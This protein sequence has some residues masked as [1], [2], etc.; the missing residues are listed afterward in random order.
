VTRTVEAPENGMA[1]VAIVI[2]TF[3]LLL[4]PQSWFP[5][6]G[7]MRIA[8]L[9]AGLAAAVL[10]WDRWTRREKLL[11]LTPEVILALALLGWAS[12]TLPLSYWPGGS[13]GLLTNMYIKSLAAFWLLAN[14]VTTTRRL[15]FLTTILG[16]CTAPLALSAFRH[17]AGGA[18]LD[19]GHP[20]VR[21]IMGYQAGLTSNPNDLALML[22]LILPLIIANFLT[23][24]RP[25]MRVFW[26]VLIAFDV[27]GVVLTFS[28]GGFLGLAT[29][30]VVYFVKLVRRPEDRAWAFAVLAVAI[31][32]LPLLPATYMN[33]LAT[34]TN[35]ESDVTGSA[36]ERWR[37]QMAALRFVM[38]HPVTGAG[39]GMDILA[40]N[41]MRGEQWK[42]VHNVYFQYAV[43]L[44]IPGV[45]LFLLLQWRVFRAVRTA[46]R[47]SAE[48]PALRDAHYLAGGLQV[49]LIVFAI[50]ALFHPVA[51]HFYFYY[52]AALALAARTAIT[53]LVS[54]A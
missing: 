21:R 25:G 50:A 43:D 48:Q 5:V 28:R 26:L 19:A 46:Q 17:F 41:Q 49:S 1:F 9:A 37:D 22:N 36:Q 44:G 7:K 13:L 45:T 3:I 29:I 10:L 32:S 31:L 53:A 30:G 18:Y 38:D 52:I 20:G 33:R 15:R 2:F 4:S 51:Y 8:F 12:L 35:I 16:L 39:I 40:L 42:S 23:A 24:R 34:I 54:H 14:I 6:L 27:V 11:E 47:D